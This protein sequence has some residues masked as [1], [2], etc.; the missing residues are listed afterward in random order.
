MQ[1]D[2]VRE[3]LGDLAA[4]IPAA[5]VAADEVLGHARRT[6][7]RRRVTRGIAA[8]AAVVVIGTLAV[9]LN[10]S[11]PTPKVRVSV[12]SPS[13]TVQA[14][15]T[16]PFTASQ[17]R[18]H[19]GIGVPSGW[20]PVD[21]G[22]ARIWVPSSWRSELGYA[23]HRRVAG[24]VSVFKLTQANCV[25]LTPTRSQWVALIPSP[26]PS[27]SGA[28]RVPGVH[29]FRVYAGRLPD[30]LVAPGSAIYAVPRLGVTIAIRG[31]M[32][33]RILDTLAPSARAIALAFAVDPTPA[34][35]RAIAADGIAASIPRE[36]TSAI[37]HQAPC[38]WSSAYPNL[39]PQFVRIRP[40]VGPSLCPPTIL[41]AAT[42]VGDGVIL[43]T[44]S[45]DVAPQRRPILVLSHGPTRVRVY[46]DKY[47]GSSLDVF[48]QNARSSTTHVLKVGLGRDGRIAGGILASIRATA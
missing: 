6:V 12:E 13:T 10:V 25:A 16:P 45:T 3:E 7:K 20:A 18:A 31:S 8:L 24:M 2:E 38:G 44:S 35:Y 17:L 11:R 33:A 29:G 34:G 39:G 14:R 30:G 41:T 1:L 40:P 36:W 42:L 27:I 23:C 5:S 28:S 4:R 32:A 26:Q 15:E 21:V 46:D 22:D 19:I 37:R 48:A 9:V 47:D 43:E